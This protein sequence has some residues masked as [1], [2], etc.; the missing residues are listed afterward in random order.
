QD[1]ESGDL[2]AVERR[3]VSTTRA[4]RSRPRRQQ[5]SSEDA[6]VPQPLSH[7]L[8]GMLRQ[9]TSSFTMAWCSADR[10]SMTRTPEATERRQLMM[11]G[12]PLNQLRNFSENIELRAREIT[13]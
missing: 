9:Q 12:E 5:Q 6:S 7:Y 3:E 2:T 13:V 4:R 1:R 10:C 11:K 8:L